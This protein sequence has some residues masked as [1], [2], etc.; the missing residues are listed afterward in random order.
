MVLI[1]GGST[2][3]ARKT[4]VCL[5]FSFT[6][7]GTTGFGSGG[8]TLAFIFGGGGGGGATGISVTGCINSTTRKFNA[9]FICCGKSRGIISKKPKMAS[10]PAAL[11]PMRSQRGDRLNGRGLPQN[12][13]PSSSYVVDLQSWLSSAF[14]LVNFPARKQELSWDS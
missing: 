7:S 11:R 2:F 4:C 6:G 13:R 9:V 14:R 8:A 1:L 12:R 10:C 3:G 5:G